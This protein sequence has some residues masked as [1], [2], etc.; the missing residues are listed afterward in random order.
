M[1][2]W[3]SRVKQ[4]RAEA[5]A[6]WDESALK[7][8]APLSKLHKFTHFWLMVWRSFTRNRCPVR[9]SALAYGSLLALIPMLAVVMSITS[10]FLKKEGEAEID[11]FIVKL[12]ASLTPPGVMSSTNTVSAIPSSDTNSAEVVAG[13]NASPAAVEEV[14]PGRVQT[15]APTA[16]TANAE[17]I[18]TRKAIARNISQFIQNTRSGTLGITGGVVLIFAGIGLL[19][20]IEDTLNDI[21]GVTSGRSWY[22]RIILYWFVISLVPLLLV[23][24][25]GLATGPHLQGTTK[26]LKALPWVSTLLFRLLP[27]MLLSVTFSLFYWLMP[28]TKVRPWAALVGGAVGGL[29]FHLNN[30]IS[31]LY[32]SRVVSN[33]K[34]YGSLGLVPVFM[35][36][37]YFCWLI[38]LF[39]AQVAYAFQN[40]NSYLE[41]KQIEA[42]NQ[43]G[44]EFVALR[45]MTAIGQRHLRG[46]PPQSVV[47]LGEELCI[48]TKLIQQTMQTLANARLVVEAAGLE[49][50]Y[51]PAQPLERITCHDILEAMRASHGQ[52]LATREGPTRNEVYGEFN[53][54]LEAE[55]HAAASVTIFALAN[56]AESKKLDGGLA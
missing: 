46:E 39:G 43:R 23:V 49:P 18:R 41:E 4:I 28:N 19:G 56:R 13:T 5:V 10:S 53:R 1:A 24:A 12:V 7:S 22:M 34:I 42:I 9:A 15:N 40:R 27:I 25:L 48:P 36:G 6:L 8:Q 33:F 17:A 47:D 21:W 32:V 54:I 55:R 50:A 11:Q 3:V 20:R 51:V 31:V 14:T 16:S 2:N 35:V 44:R 38:L 26:F 52:E 30:L 45:L 29:L 37:L